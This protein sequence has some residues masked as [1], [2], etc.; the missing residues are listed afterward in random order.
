MMKK[1]AA[2]T[3]PFADVRAAAQVAGGAEVGFLVAHRQPAVAVDD[4]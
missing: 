4:P 3:W 1:S 2:A